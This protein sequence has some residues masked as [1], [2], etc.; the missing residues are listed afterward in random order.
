MSF[1]PGAG[2]FADDAQRSSARL[3]F[4]YPSVEQMRTGADRL[5]EL[6]RRTP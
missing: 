3:S 6:V 5:V 2:F 4:S 1:V